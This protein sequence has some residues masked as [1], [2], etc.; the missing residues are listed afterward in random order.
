VVL[1][2]GEKQGQSWAKKIRS[3]VHPALFGNVWMLMF[4][5]YKMLFL[6]F[7]C[8][9]MVESSLKKELLKFFMH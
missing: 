9:F 7:F 5:I 2:N 3:V 8:I 1:W 6:L 4:Q